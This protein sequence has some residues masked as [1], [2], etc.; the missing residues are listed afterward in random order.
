M[1]N[2]SW[3]D[4]WLHNITSNH[5][6][7]I[8]LFMA[9]HFNIY[10]LNLTSIHFYVRGSDC[11]RICVYVNQRFV[12]HWYCKSI[13]IIVIALL[14]N[15]KSKQ[16]ASCFLTLLHTSL[17]FLQITVVILTVTGLTK[18][19]TNH[20]ILVHSERK[21]YTVYVWCAV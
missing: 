19:A 18:S 16:M 11:L 4:P 20:C 8:H 7:S 14:N 13:I 17:L 10:S 3:V 5:I 12:L 6:I 9:S 1:M 15:Y 21:C 2:E